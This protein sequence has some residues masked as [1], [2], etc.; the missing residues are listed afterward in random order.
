M[1]LSQLLEE[2]DYKSKNFIDLNVPKVTSNSKE[3]SSG[4]L[5][6]AINGV[7]VDGH[8]F[9][10]SAIENGAAA[11]VYEQ[12]FDCP[13]NVVAIK[14]KNSRLVYS[15]ICANLFKNPAQRL[16]FIGI[17][18]TNGKTSTAYLTYHIL[19]SCGYKVGLIG[20]VENITGKGKTCAKF[21]TPDA[22]NMQ[23]LL[24]EMVETDIEY[25]VME[26]SSHALSQDRVSDISFEA[27]AFTNLTQ[28]HLDYHHTMENYKNE[29]L[30]LMHKCKKAVVNL[31]DPVSNEFIDAVNGLVYTIGIKQ[32]AY[33]KAEHIK[34]M[35][36]KTRFT[37]S[38]IEGVYNAT[39]AIRGLFSV[40]NALTAIALSRCVDI[41]LKKAVK[42]L[43]MATGVSG[44]MENFETGRDFNIVLDYA[45]TPD[46]LEKA[47]TTLKEQTDLAR[48][49]VVFGCGGDRDKDKRH[50]MGEIDIK[51]ADY[52]II[53]SDNPRTE[54]PEEIIEDI[55][56]GI[57]TSK[58]PVEIIIDRK[59]A[60]E[61][62]IE[63]AKTNDVILLAGKGHETYQI[64]KDG[65]IH[66]DE[67][68]V[69]AEILKLN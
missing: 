43:S 14:V 58:T 4:D 29:K 3:I 10:K 65:K 69:L 9:I 12:D 2:I 47:L 25:V 37:I 27:A 13:S 26:V 59:T 57:K 20:T 53:T 16:T 1:L 17:T 60:I 62:S 36:S 61:H 46:S 24:A 19:K 67:R 48:L 23:K 55:K 54:N 40:Y 63:I 42:A 8:K 50:I 49:I 18:G 45:H 33:F 51:N 64:L 31:D 34:P 52:V 30:K 41:P 44:R 22:M 68:E 21:T 32:D 11:I 5:F 38:S 66:F 56:K 6:V 39:I 15:R 7:A 28:D 35:S